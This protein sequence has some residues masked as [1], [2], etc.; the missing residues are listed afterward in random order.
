MLTITGFIIFFLGHRPRKAAQIKDAPGARLRRWHAIT[1]VPV[2]LGIL[3]LIVSGLPWTGV[4]GSVVQQIASE[5]GSSL[6]GDDP[7]ARSTIGGLIESTSGTSAEA[8]WALGNGP[9]GASATM[10]S[11]V[12]SIDDAVAAAKAEGAAQPYSVIYPVDE[13]GVFSVMSSQ[14]ND[15]GNPAE[16]EVSLEQTLHV[17]Q[18]SGEIVD[19]YGYD[20][21]SMVAQIVSQGIA[22]HEGRRAGPLNAVASTMFCL[23]V[24]FMCVSAPLMWWTRRGT[25]SGMAAPRAK[26]PLWGNWLLVA[27]MVALG[28]FLPLFGLSV[29]VILALDQFLIRQIPRMKKFFGS[30]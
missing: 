9:T 10:A 5:N 25:A 22:V 30:V 17:D 13:T 23:A 6:W 2:G 26:L 15:N 24:I 16:S 20:D 28:I 3:M 1:G 11:S 14:W 19:T 21:Y 12:I 7:G 18:Y 8:G 4:W 27:T 29:V